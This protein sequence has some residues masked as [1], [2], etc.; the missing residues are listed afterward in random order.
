MF[1]ATR[2]GDTVDKQKRRRIVTVRF[3]DGTSE[4]EKDFEFSIGTE[5]KRMK[6]TVKEYLDELNFVPEKITGDI[7]DYVKPAED[8]GPTAEE[9][10]KTEWDAN[11]S[12][13]REVQ[14]LIELGVLTGNEGPVK[15][16]QKKV[17][18]DFKS[19]YIA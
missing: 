3:A 10:A 1:T 8:E 2:L 16:L 5:V 11:L 13:L 15:A 17:K 7:A 4:F 12:K 18:D 19:A 6:K 14:E 9:L